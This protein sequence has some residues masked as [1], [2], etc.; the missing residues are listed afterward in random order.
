MDLRK[1]SNENMRQHSTGKCELFISRR[2]Y[3]NHMPQRAFRFPDKKCTTLALQL[4][5]FESSKVSGPGSSRKK[6]TDVMWTVS[7]VKSSLG[8]TSD[9]ERDFNRLLRHLLK[10]N[11]LMRI[12]GAVDGNDAY[13]SRTAETLRLVGH[14]YEY[15][16]RGRPGVDAVRWE[17][18]PKVIPVRNIEPEDFMQH[19][20]HAV[21]DASSDQSATELGDAIRETISGIVSYFRDKEG[22][23]IQSFQ[24]SNLMQRFTAF[25]MHSD[26][27]KADQFWWLVWAPV[28]RWRSCFHH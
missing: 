27:E 4:F 10:E 2:M 24:N 18:V 14:T 5:E 7:D 13:I 6:L 28:R 23:L 16:N 15:W 26:M 22:F 3:L 8:L 11:Q 20:I 21:T 12:P 1:L 25:V 17:I 9:E 19:V